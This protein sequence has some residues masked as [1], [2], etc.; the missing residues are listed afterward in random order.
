M[1]HM[2]IHLKSTSIYR[3]A[4]AANIHSSLF[5]HHITAVKLTQIKMSPQ[6]VHPLI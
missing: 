4:M 6:I 5:S 3:A 2:I 1:R